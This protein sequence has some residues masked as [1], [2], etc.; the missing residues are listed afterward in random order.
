MTE[1]LL[2]CIAA[3]AAVIA[4]LAL[5]GLLWD[6]GVSR[7]L[8]EVP[9]TLSLRR[10]HTPPSCHL[11]PSSNVFA[12]EFNLYF[13]SCSHIV[14]YA[15]MRY[16]GNSVSILK[17]QES[18]HAKMHLAEIK[19]SEEQGQVCRRLIPLQWY[20]DRLLLKSGRTIGL[21]LSLAIETAASIS[22]YTLARLPFCRH[23]SDL[24][25][26]HM[27]EEVEHGIVTAHHLRRQSHFLPRMLCFP[28]AVGIFAGLFLQPPLTLLLSSPWLLLRWRTYPDAVSYYLSFGPAFFA[29]LVFLCAHFLPPSRRGAVG[30]TA[31]MHERFL[32]TL[33]ELVDQRPT[34]AHSVER[35]ETFLVPC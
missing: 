22:F 4:M 26:L 30:E 9:I 34:L 15:V 5:H 29:S 10:F 2:V 12:A 31:A 25:L 8:R 35:A 13:L 3:S 23:L 14:D 24:T 7:R 16:V 32:T 27:W 33:Q 17:K 6:N 19:R 18:R 1:T 20:L 28:I 11:D 21:T